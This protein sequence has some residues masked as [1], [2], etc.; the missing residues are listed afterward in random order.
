MKQEN[1]SLR[2]NQMLLETRNALIFAEERHGVAGAALALR[3][4]LKAVTERCNHTVQ[5]AHAEVAAM[6]AE[7]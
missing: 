4:K 3:E 1:R 5:E 2:E 7:L 6:K